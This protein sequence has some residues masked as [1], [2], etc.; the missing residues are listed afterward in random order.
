[1]VTATTSPMVASSWSG[2]RSETVAWRACCAGKPLCS[3][4]ET[5]RVAPARMS[6]SGEYETVSFATPRSWS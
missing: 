2:V 3:S 4:S 6:P 5:S 1:M